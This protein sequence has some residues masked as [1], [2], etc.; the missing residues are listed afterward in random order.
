MLIRE[1]LLICQSCPFL[2]AP[3]QER[4]SSPQGIDIVGVDNGSHG[5]SCESHNICGH[6][7]VVKDDILYCKWAVQ[8]FDSDVPET[9]V[10][11]FK[12]APDGHVGC[13]V[14][15][16]PRRVIKASRSK[17]DRKFKDG[18]KRYDGTWLMVVADLRISD[19][20]AERSRSHRNFG[21]LY[22]HIAKDDFLVGKNPFK[23]C[24]VF[25]ESEKENTFQLP[26]GG[27]PDANS[28][29]DDDS[30]TCTPRIERRQPAVDN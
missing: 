22:C 10:Q 1:E 28:L 9:C 14:G 19:N 24:I 25:P 8:K 23:D 15:Y 13:H 6:C 3:G 27:S 20:S 2:Q 29:D 4:A 30:R 12:Q 16:L 18:G 11:V 17:D 5:R 26:P 21:I 7:F